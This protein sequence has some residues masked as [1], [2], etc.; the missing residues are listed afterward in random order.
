M[1]RLSKS[2][3]HDHGLVLDVETTGLM[4]GAS[5]PDVTAVGIAPLPDGQPS[6]FL[7]PDFDGL[8]S[9]FAGSRLFVGFNIAA[10]DLP[11]LTSALG[12]TPAGRVID[13][14]HA[15]RAHCGHR[16][17]LQALVL[18]TLGKSRTG[19]GLAAKRAAR[20]GRAAAVRRHVHSDV[21]LTRELFHFGRVN[22]FVLIEG[23]GS[24]QRIP[25]DWSLE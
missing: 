19:T 11:I 22:G 10:F 13:M 24:L 20:A 9:L 15:V 7:P 25:V 21:V 1:T 12:W 23:Q 3:D 17:P 2:S 8:L 18:A 5:S 16:L 4:R 6:I 14:L